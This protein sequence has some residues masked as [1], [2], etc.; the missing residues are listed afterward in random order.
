VGSADLPGPSG[1]QPH[2]AVVWIN[3]KI[4]DLGTAPEDA[5]SRSRAI[6]ARGQ[7]VGGSSDCPNF[8]HAFVWDDKTLH[9][10]LEYRHRSGFG[11]SAHERNQHQ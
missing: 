5:C 10:G 9:G 6:N 2:D 3:G 4:H 7:V 8:L 1:N 11:F